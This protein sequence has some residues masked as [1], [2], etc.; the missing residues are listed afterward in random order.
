MMCLLLLSRV[1]IS[2]ETLDYLDGSYKVEDGDGP[3]RD[4]YL[5]EHGVI[6]FLVINPKVRCKLLRVD[7]QLLVDS[8][9]ICKHSQILFLIKTSEWPI[10]K[11]YQKVHS[12]RSSTLTTS[13]FRKFQKDCISD[14]W[15]RLYIKR[16]YDKSPSPTPHKCISLFYFYMYKHF[17]TH[18]CGAALGYNSICLWPHKG[19]ILILTPYSHSL[20]FPFT[21]PIRSPVAGSTG[22]WVGGPEVPEIAELSLCIPE[23][24]RCETYLI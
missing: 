15:A 22:R 6:T 4:P 2:S 12:D 8:P 16:L 1:H 21:P 18:L 3:N 9:F 13:E 7:S 20:C 14:V 19:L 11:R 24:R 5:K 10:K 17:I 23:R